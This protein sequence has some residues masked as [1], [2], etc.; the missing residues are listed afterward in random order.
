[1]EDDWRRL[2][3][4]ALEAFSADCEAGERNAVVVEGTYSARAPRSAAERY[5]M[6]DFV[7]Y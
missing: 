4:A 2:A 5:F 3:N 6:V 7:I 1:M